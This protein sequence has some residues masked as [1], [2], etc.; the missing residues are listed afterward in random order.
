M[1]PLKLLTFKSLKF[2][3]IFNATYFFNYVNNSVG[4][5]SLNKLRNFKFMRFLC[6]NKP[7]Q[8][9]SF[10][11][12]MHKKSTFTWSINIFGRSANI[13]PQVIQCKWMDMCGMWTLWGSISHSKAVKLLYHLFSASTKTHICT[14]MFMKT[15]LFC[16]SDRINM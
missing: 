12:F 14:Y 13:L 3:I 10:Y 11:L 6:A 2:V 7:W 8:C 1:R 4:G 15:Y 16:T 9:S 5:N